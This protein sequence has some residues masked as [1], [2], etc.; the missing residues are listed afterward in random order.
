MFSIVYTVFATAEVFWLHMRAGWHR[1]ALLCS[2]TLSVIYSFGL[3]LI[4]WFLI[5]LLIRNKNFFGADR[6]THQDLKLECKDRG[7]E[8]GL[9]LLVKVVLIPLAV[10]L[11]LIILVAV[12]GG[13]L[14]A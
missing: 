6:L 12:I 14:D 4:S 13:A 3:D 1:K 7:L 11:I 10:L 2:C 9:S 5:Y 8:T